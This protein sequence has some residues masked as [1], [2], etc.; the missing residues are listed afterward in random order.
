MLNT[1]R[2]A[3]LFMTVLVDMI[4]FGIVL[5]LLP[6]YAESFG[7][8]PSEVTLLVASFSAMQFVAVPIWGK[9]SD[10]LGRRPFI[11]AGLFASAVSYLIFGLAESLAML[12]VSRVAAGAAGRGAGCA[13]ICVCACLA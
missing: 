13:W 6:Y 9:V 11:V 5:P 1:S 10:R 2:L 7:A 3:V 4:G 8:S 12:F